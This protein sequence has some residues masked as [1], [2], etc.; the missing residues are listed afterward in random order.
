MERRR[1]WAY[2]LLM[3][4]IPRNNF[5]AEASPTPKSQ[6]FGWEWTGY[7]A[8][9]DRQTPRDWQRHFKNLTS[10]KA[11]WQW[12]LNQAHF[13]AADGDTPRR[14]AVRM[15]TVTPGLECFLVRINRKEWTPSEAAFS[16]ALHPGENL[17]EM[18]V[19]NQAG[20]LGPV[21][22][23]KVLVEA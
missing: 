16:W 11:D 14:I 23:L 7:W 20:V 21:S 22:F 6:G 5:Y 4:M 12:T 15:G 13:A 8:W 10:R 2:W 9:E 19:R 1:P 3:R 17:L 18:R